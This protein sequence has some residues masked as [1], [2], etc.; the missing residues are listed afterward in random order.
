MNGVSDAEEKARDI[1]SRIKELKRGENGPQNRRAIKDLYA[2]LDEI[3]F[4]KDYMCLIID[5]EKDYHRACSGFSINGVKYKRLLGTVGGVKNSTIVFVSE[6]CLDELKRRIDNGRNMNVPMVPAKLEAYKALSCS[7]SIPVSMPNGILVVSD[8]P[9]SFT[10]DVI[11]LSSDGDEPKA[12]YLPNHTEKVD[13]SDG[14]GLMLPC[15]AERW[16]HELGLDYTMS[17]CNTR[18]S[19]E[20]GMVFS[21][22]F[23]DF[24][25]NV[26]HSYIVKDVWGNDVDVRGVEL[27][28]TE[29]MLKLWDSYS[30]MESYMENCIANKYSIS[31]TKTCPEVLESE[32]SLNYQ[33]IQSYQLTDN[34]IEELIA[35]TAEEISDVIHGDWRKSVLFLKGSSL[36]ES[37]IDRVEDGFI[38]AMM[39]DSRI[40]DDPFVQSSI[41][42]IIKNRINE[43]KV[44]V[45]KVHGNYSIA[46]G[47][48]YALCQHMFGLPVT[49]LLKANEIYN[50]FWANCG[51]K[52]LACFRA[53]M[54]VHSNIRIVNVKDDDV[55]RHWY[56]HIKTGTVFNAWDGCTCAMNGMD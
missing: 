25:E 22:D 17:G 53:P 13:A 42:Q 46:S 7:A 33:F 18:F 55:V 26:A 30:N 36:N 37:N 2:A 28:L 48:P 27:I 1:K 19:F 14:Y 3:Q 38:K 15:L 44:G 32:R 34:D 50:E 5:K 6:R 51:A 54:S 43:A 16:S 39:I 9:G 10:E 12:E 47:D 23:L 56:G 35:P 45:L 40:A 31:V 52:K 20:K 11:R 49:G 41:Y 24:A 29:G 21:F 8:C 4:K